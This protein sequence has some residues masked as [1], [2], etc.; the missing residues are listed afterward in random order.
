MI[1][2]NVQDTLSRSTENEEKNGNELHNSQYDGR[3]VGKI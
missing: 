2:M 1:F 3:R